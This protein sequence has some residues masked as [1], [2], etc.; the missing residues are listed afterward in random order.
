MAIVMYP[1]KPIHWVFLVVELQPYASLTSKEGSGFYTVHALVHIKDSPAFEHR[2]LNLDISRN[3][4]EPGD[5][6]RIIEA[7]IYN[8]MNRLRIHA[9][10]SQSWPQEVPALPELAAKGAYDRD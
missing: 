3:H 2:G 10:D 6:R 7:M 9:S 8:K 4:I 5:V 1:T